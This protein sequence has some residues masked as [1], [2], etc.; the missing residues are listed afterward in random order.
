VVYIR[1]TQLLRP[2]ALRCES[3]GER[4]VNF[5][6]WPLAASKLR[7]LRVAALAVEEP[8]DEAGLEKKRGV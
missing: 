3:P 8:L 1:L 4:A 5:A 2:A 6:S 7:H